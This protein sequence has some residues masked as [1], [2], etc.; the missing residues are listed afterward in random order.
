MLRPARTP[1][2]GI[3]G[4]APIPYIPRSP[5]HPLACPSVTEEWRNHSRHSEAAAKGPIMADIHHRRPRRPDDRRRAGFHSPGRR[6][7]GKLAAMLDTRTSLLRRVRD[8]AD[9]QS[10]GEFVALYEP[11]LLSYV[12][13][14]GLHDH[15]AQDVVQG[16]FISLLRK[17]P[18]FDLDHRKGRFRT[19]LWQVA[20]NAV[21]DWARG[22]RR[23]QRAEDR[24]RDEWHEQATEPDDDWINMHR[25][26]V[27]QFVTDR[28][29]AATAP[30]TWACFER[31]LLQGRP[32]AEV[33]AELDL[34][35]NTVYVNATRVL[36]RVREQCA[37]YREDLGDD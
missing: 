33:G 8:P 18:S 27:L 12:R 7:G 32:G 6:R 3:L 20:H 30:K 23:I 28:V 16:I 17:L 4:P 15:D 26:R 11:L 37:A 29:R 25:R 13:K 34:P 21:V 5:C 31:H 2:T 14:R 19:W 1:L 24:R 35:A 22:R 36:K 9:R 10:W